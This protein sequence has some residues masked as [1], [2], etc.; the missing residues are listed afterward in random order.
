MGH[1]ESVATETLTIKDFIDFDSEI[2]EYQTFVVV[3]K[4]STGR[5]SPSLTD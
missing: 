5:L 2:N 1:L 4:L 3:V